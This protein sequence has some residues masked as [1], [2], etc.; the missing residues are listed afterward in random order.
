MQ[1]CYLGLQQAELL[2][3][4]VLQAFYSMIPATGV[5]CS[6]YYHTQEREPPRVTSNPLRCGKEGDR[7]LVLGPVVDIT[8]QMVKV[9]LFSPESW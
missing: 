6:T 1:H 8:S 5:H 3:D 2:T 7:E 4:P 9:W